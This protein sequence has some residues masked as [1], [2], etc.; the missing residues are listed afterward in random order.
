M[1]LVGMHLE[2]SCPPNFHAA[3][4]ARMTQKALSRH[5]FLLGLWLAAAVISTS[6]LLAAEPSAAHV[7]FNR[8][9]RPILS[10]TCFPC[11]GFDSN[12]RKADLRLDTSEG[13]VAPHEGRQA[14]KTNPP[15]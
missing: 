14:V 6:E 7:L 9:I 5:C 12:K 4:A 11:H 3:K 8:D 10:D 15:G 1:T 2:R 13:M